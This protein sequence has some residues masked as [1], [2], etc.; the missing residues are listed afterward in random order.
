MSEDS[1]WKAS[2][3]K[4]VIGLYGSLERVLQ[5]LNLP[6]LPSLNLSNS[7]PAMYFEADD[8]G[9]ADD[10][11]DDEP[12]AV[13]SPKVTPITD[14]LSHVPIESLYQ[15]TGMKSLRAISRRA[16]ASSGNRLLHATRIV[17]Q[18]ICRCYRQK[19]AKILGLAYEE[20]R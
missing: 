14:N 1:R 2:V 6:E 9:G 10:E 4:D 3:T 19:S 18:R 13:H 5:L 12:S 16:V 8:P 17:V 15:I 7:D 11:D 20:E